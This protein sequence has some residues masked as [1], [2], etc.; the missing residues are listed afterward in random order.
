MVDAS[1][2]FRTGYLPNT[3]QKRY[4]VRAKFS[5]YATLILSALH[6]RETWPQ[7]LREGHGLRIFSDQTA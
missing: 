5:V 1:A 4:L 6:D 2:D 7:A 3:N